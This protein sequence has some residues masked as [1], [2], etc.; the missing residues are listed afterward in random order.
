MK[1]GLEEFAE[2]EL[3]LLGDGDGEMQILM[4][5]NIMEMVRV[6]ASQGHSGFSANAAI[7]ALE[8]LLLQAAFPALGQS[9]GR[10]RWRMGFSGTGDAQA[11]SGMR[12]GLTAR[13]TGLRASYSRTT[14]AR[15]GSQTGTATFL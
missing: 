2:R 7:S 10:T 4:N 9:G 1:S 6:F 14:A 15:R 13:H 11:Y 5:K 3:A 8:R 12:A